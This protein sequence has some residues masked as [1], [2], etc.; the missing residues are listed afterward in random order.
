MQISYNMKRRGLLGSVGPIG[1]LF[2]GCLGGG[3]GDDQA[4]NP[5][6]SD[7][8]TSDESDD[9]SG[10][11]V[12]TKGSRTYEQ[13]HWISISS[14]RLPSDVQTEVNAALA[15]GSYETDHLLFEEAVDPDHSYIIVDDTPYD[16]TVERKGET[17]ILELHEADVVHA[18]EP[19]TV[20]VK[21]R[22]TVEHRVQ[23][24]L[25]NG[26]TYI[27]D[28]VEIDS[29]ETVVLDGPTAFGGYE[30][31]TRVLT[32]DHEEITDV[33]GVGEFVLEG[34]VEIRDDGVMFV[35]G[36][37]DP[38]PCPWEASDTNRED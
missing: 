12:E 21:N 8:G 9:S 6:D 33:F 19:R 11:V 28:T 10:S 1:A 26:E 20:R 4:D 30:L 16:P 31:T 27:D 36:V 17:A 24:E 38:L 34:I 2:A 15:G 23:I 37:I 29:E 3:P 22:D 35:Q 25:V 7:A 32:G 14:E 13:C 5:H 18:P